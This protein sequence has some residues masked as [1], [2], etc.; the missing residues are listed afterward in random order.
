MASKSP[1]PGVIP[2]PHGRSPWLI[3][4]GAPNNLLTGMILQVGGIWNCLW[5]FVNGRADGRLWGQGMVP[6]SSLRHEPFSGPLAPHWGVQQFRTET[7]AKKGWKSLQSYVFFT[8]DS[9][10][11]LILIIFVQV[12]GDFF[13]I[14]NHRN[15]RWWWFKRSSPFEKGSSHRF[16]ASFFKQY[17]WNQIKVVE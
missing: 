3:N 13:C 15:W 9:D 7:S 4:G 8:G 11:L 1:R 2:F 10:L 12:G 14:P 17:G 6:T 16:Q 5:F